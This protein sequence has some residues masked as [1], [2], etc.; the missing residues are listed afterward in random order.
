M[1]SSSLNCMQTTSVRID[2]TTHVALKRLAADLG[3]TV[4]QTVAL[5]VRQLSQ[6]RIGQQLNTPL[7]AA[8]V[9][10]L[11]AELG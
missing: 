1:R 4:G 2:S 7:T 11:D 8:E 9:D 5:A 10:W 3:T 6:Q